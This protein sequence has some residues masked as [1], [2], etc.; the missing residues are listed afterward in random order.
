M[1]DIQ[2]T[3]QGGETIQLPASTSVQEAFAKLLSNKQRKLA[4]AAIVDGQN[5]DLSTLLVQDAVI[6]PIQID[7][8]AGLEILRHSAAHV[9][10]Q[11]VRDLFGDDVKVAIGPAIE[12]GF[13]YD[14]AFAKTFSPEDFEKIEARM[15][16][17]AQKALP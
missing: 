2:V 9:M 1:T 3:L 17:I 12:D 7:T 8:D 16:A 10:A 5:V 6:S 11:A 4:V 13:Y 15:E 14:F